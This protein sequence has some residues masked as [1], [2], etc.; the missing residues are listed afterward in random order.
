[1]NYSIL[2]LSKVQRLFA[3]LAILALVFGPVANVFAQEVPDQTI[4]PV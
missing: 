1:M 3:V 2:S 4:T